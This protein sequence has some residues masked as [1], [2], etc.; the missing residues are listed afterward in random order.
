MRIVQRIS[1]IL[2]FALQFEAAYSDTSD[3][4]IAQALELLQQNNKPKALKLL[5]KAFEAAQDPETVKDAAVL[6]L[7]ASPPNYPKRDAYLRYLSSRGRDH[8]DYWKWHKE[9]GDRAFDR[10]DFQ[11]AEESYLNAR[12]SAPD[13]H[14]IDYKLA[15]TFWNQKRRNEAMSLFLDLLADESLRANLQ[16]DIAKLWWETGPLPSATFSKMLSVTVEIREGIF[17]EVWDLFPKDQS[18]QPKTTEQLRQIRD[19]P[20]SKSYWSDFLSRDL[21]FKKDPCFMIENILGP[22][23]FAATTVLLS[24]AKASGH[25]DLSVLGRHFENRLSE[26]DENFVRAYAQIM[27]ESNQSKRAASL[28]FGWSGYDNAPSDYLSIVDQILMAIPDAD[29]QAIYASTAPEKFERIIQTQKKSNLLARLQNID[30]ERWLNFEEKSFTTGKISRVFL[31][32]KAAFLAKNY[33]NRRTEIESLVNELLESPKDPEEHAVKSSLQSLREKSSLSLPKVF[34]ESFTKDLSSWTTQIDR[35]LST[36]HQLSS[37]WQLLVLPLVKEQLQKN[38]D[39][40][41]NQ[42]NEAELPEDAPDD[43]VPEFLNKKADI[44]DQLIKRYGEFLRS[45]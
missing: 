31:L 21:Y 16:R 33:A 32:K 12:P 17:S 14:V 3:T 1:A 4:L 36:Y 37:D 27:I 6:I 10:A 45:P 43:L 15:W 40:L 5:E 7:E 28:M 2:F 19:D 9:L 23:D 30:P 26:A 35:D 18:A 11:A 44:R 29:L 42:I 13:A 41:V 24:C 34:G 39:Q 20:R 22:E 38:V 8:P 25:P